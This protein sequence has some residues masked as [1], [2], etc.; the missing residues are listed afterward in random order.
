MSKVRLVGIAGGTASGK[1]WLAAFVKARLGGRA[2]LLSQDW[3]YKDQSGAAGT[4]KKRLN[5]DHPRAIEHGL[6]IAH[7]DALRGGRAIQAP[8]YVLRRMRGR[9]GRFRCRRRRW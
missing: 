3:Y 1:S 2:A 6:L 8:Q 4:A 7:L 5:F 9:R